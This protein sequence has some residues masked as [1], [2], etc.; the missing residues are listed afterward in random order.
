M[1]LFMFLTALL[2]AVYFGIRFYLL[3]EGLK[4]I[5]RELREIK[6]DVSQNQILHLPAPDSD[7][8]ILLQ[9]I[10]GILDEVRQEREEY[11]R[12][13]RKFQAQ[14]EAVSHDLRTPLTVILGYLRFLQMQER[15]SAKKE[16]P[17]DQKEMLDTMERKA[18]AME[19]LISTFYDYSRL[20]SG[21]YQL[22]F[23]TIDAGK[24]LRETFVDHCRVFEETALDVKTDFP[25][26]PICIKGERAALERIFS[27]LLQNTE[28]YAQSFLH[29]SIQKNDQDVCIIFENDS[30]EI[31]PADLPHLFERFYRKDSARSQDGTGLG[32]TI[33]KCLAEEMKGKLDAEIIEN[34]N[35]SSYLVRF[36]LHLRSL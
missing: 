27:N 3:K 7:L 20:S 1:L 2:L 26:Y 33:A 22:Q 29:I 6:Q 19:K 15:E 12:R 18:R 9:S 10:N 31:C 25:D 17:D 28:R 24:V 4:E 30:Q 11:A 5:D 23:E 21:D 8:E 34:A 32:L 35:S 16:I 13:E 14:M 36:V